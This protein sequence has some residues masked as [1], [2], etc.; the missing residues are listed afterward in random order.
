[1]PKPDQVDHDR[2]PDGPEAWRQGLTG[3]AATH[4]KQPTRPRS[5]G[6]NRVFRVLSA[7]CV[8]QPARRRLEGAT[9][10]RGCNTSKDLVERPVRDVHDAWRLAYAIV[11]DGD[12]ATEAVRKAFVEAAP[13]EDSALPSGRTAPPSRLDFLAATFRIGQTRAAENPNQESGSAVTT[14]L[15]QLAPEQRGALWL[16]KVDELDDEALGT[17]LGLTAANAGHVASRAAEWLDV[18]LDHDSGPLCP[19]ETRLDDFLNNRLPEDEAAGMKDHVPDCPTCRTKA[20]AFAELADLRAV[21][22]AA[23]P[24]PPAGLD[25]AALGRLDRTS[26][27]NGSAHIGRADAPDTRGANAGAVLRRSSHP[28]PDRHRTPAPDQPYRRADEPECTPGHCPRL[29]D[30]HRRERGRRGHHGR[31]AGEERPGCRRHYHHHSQSDV[32]NDQALVGLAPGIFAVYAAKIPGAWRWRSVQR[33]MT[34]PSG[35][36]STTQPSACNWRRMSSA[37]A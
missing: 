14:A 29:V 21:L 19:D 13:P 31:P 20:R 24:E 5:P 15:W 26:P 35:V 34:V 4:L 11:A 32:P 16:A 9:R 33:R 10:R 37:S 23:V 30:D 7:R 25:L 1:M 36:S 18:T 27:A 22:L 2:Q 3:P 12:L 17:V 8:E 28:G 6:S